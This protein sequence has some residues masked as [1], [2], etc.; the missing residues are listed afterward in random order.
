VADSRWPEVAWTMPIARGRRSHLREDGA[1]DGMSPADP[2][3]VIGSALL[4]QVLTA[5]D[6]VDQPIDASSA[7]SSAITELRRSSCST[8]RAGAAR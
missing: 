2:S 8:G 4:T 3:P 1:A 6:L 5:L 7:Q